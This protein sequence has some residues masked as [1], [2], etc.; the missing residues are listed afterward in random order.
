[1]TISQISTSPATLSASNKPC[2]QKIFKIEKILGKRNKPDSSKNQEI[3][4]SNAKRTCNEIN[5]LE[6]Y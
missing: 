4:P 6:N 5:H 2:Q 3:K 1:M